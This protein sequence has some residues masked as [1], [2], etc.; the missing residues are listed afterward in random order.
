MNGTRRI[1]RRCGVGAIVGLALVGTGP[2]A[3]GSVAPFDPVAPGVGVAAGHTLSDGKVRQITDAIRDVPHRGRAFPAIPVA[4]ADGSALEGPAGTVGQ[5]AVGLIAIGY[6]TS[7][8]RS[9]PRLPA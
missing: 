3:V 2:A 7:R 9:A 4:G 5:I 1:G 6:A 8:R